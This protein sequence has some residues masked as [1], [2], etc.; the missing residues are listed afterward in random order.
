MRSLSTHWRLVVPLLGEEIIMLQLIR[1]NAT[2]WIAWGIVILICIPFAL[3]GVYDYVSP[4]PTV[5]VATVNGT[6]LTFN[7]FRQSYRKHRNRL[8]RLLGGQVDLSELDEGLIRQQT[9]DALIEEELLIQAAYSDGFR[10]GDEQLARAIHAQ[11]PF[12]VDG[13]FDVDRYELWLRTQGYS[14]DG[15]EYELRRSLV[16]EQILAGVGGSAIVT[17]SEV[18]K[19][20][21]LV[22]QKRS[23]FEL[24]IPLSYFGDVEI[25]DESV[26]RY[27]TDHSATLLTEEA[28]S[29]E[30]IELDREA[31]AE[32]IEISEDDLRALYERNQANFIQPERR[33]AS[34]ILILLPE[35]ADESTS[36]Q[37]NEKAQSIRDQALAGEDFGQ[38]AKEFSQ[39]P[40]SSNNDGSLGYFERG[41]MVPIFESTAFAL[42][43][44]EISEVVQSKFGF[45]IIKLTGID[46]SRTKSFDEARNEIAEDLRSTEADQL[47]Y[48]QLDELEIIAFEVPDTLE[49]AADALGLEIMEVPFFTREG[50]ETDLVAANP[51]VVRAAFND[52]VLISGNNSSAIGL[53]NNRAV[54][55]R[56][57]DYEPA[58]EQTLEEARPWIIDHLRDVRAKAEIAKLADDSIAE[59]RIGLSRDI[60]SEQLQLDWVL[61][62]D[63]TRN[64][65]AV[66]PTV[67]EKT[68]EMPRP[69]AGIESYAS[70]TT[71]T[72][73]QV[74]I[75][76]TDV[77]DGTAQAL[78]DDQKLSRK[79]K[80]AGEYA[81]SAFSAYAQSLRD[82][83]DIVVNEEN[84][85]R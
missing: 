9:L 41:D 3:W 68:F 47:Y 62:P 4:N 58:R 82:Q 77:V 54:V 27:Y 23:F 43:L 51:Q 29:I 60:L 85:D 35:D 78:S 33:E 50:S 20:V 64:S 69:V 24:T 56:V 48:E 73:E 15:F 84:L 45:H 32:R 67:V 16:S 28:V 25:S 46:L 11:E 75:A 72:G 34:H 52:D 26:Q 8:R 70:V 55:L 59:L 2:G 6:E 71:S 14:P 30:Y 31:L 65:S 37:I 66:E 7:Q 63:V 5:S 19:T 39:D 83:A 80:L 12:Q 13:A 21:K 81:R 40:G 17:N 79:K 57:T 18:V 61:R 38:L 36:A 49:V 22:G 44:D 76:L 74:L 1:D 53:P 42:G 10:I